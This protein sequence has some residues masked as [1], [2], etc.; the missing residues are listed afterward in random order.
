[1]LRNQSIHKVF[2]CLRNI[3]SQ[4]HFILTVK[5]PKVRLVEAPIISTDPE[6]QVSGKI[7]LS[8]LAR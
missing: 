2:L 3:L 5:Y 4:N 7:F 6:F 8:C 1:M